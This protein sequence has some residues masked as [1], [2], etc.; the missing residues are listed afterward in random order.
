MPEEFKSLGDFINHDSS[1]NGIR[2]TIRQM[3]VITRFYEIFPDLKKV[4]IPVKMENNKLHLKV[5]NPAWRS[6]LKFSETKIISKINEFL[7]G[8]IV[9]EIRFMS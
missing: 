9:A 2:K 5:E 6:E 8:E 7:G 4:A 3:D 1:F